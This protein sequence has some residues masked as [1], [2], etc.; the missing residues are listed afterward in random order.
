MVVC[1]AP[2]H[3]VFKEEKL[4]LKVVFARGD[5]NVTG[6]KKHGAP[7]LMPNTVICELH[8]NEQV[9][10]IRAGLTGKLIEVNSSL[11]K[12]QDVKRPDSI[13]EV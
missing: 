8:F 2:Q 9:L 11:A 12:L 4:E 13:D 10:K 3:P 1:L 6:K 7:Q 5:E